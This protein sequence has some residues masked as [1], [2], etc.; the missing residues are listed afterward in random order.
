MGELREMSHKGDTKV[1]WD[2]D[3]ATEVDNAR[4]TFDDLK[5][6]GFLAYTVEAKGRK[7]KIIRE[8]DPDAEKIIMAPPMAGG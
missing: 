1:I 2:A 3:N 7:G 4:R 6:K 5:K 8:F